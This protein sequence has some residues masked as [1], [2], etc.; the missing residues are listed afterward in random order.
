V[1]EGKKMKILICDGLHES[2]LE[3]L[4]TTEGIDADAPDQWSMDEIREHLPDYDG[5]PET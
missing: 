2:G 4:K 3:L 1:Q 5:M